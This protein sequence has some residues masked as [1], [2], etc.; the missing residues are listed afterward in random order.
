[1]SELI[2]AIIKT[3]ETTADIFAKALVNINGLSEFEIGEKILAEVAK[4]NE[5]F[6]E[7]WYSP[8]PKGVAVLLDQKL[9]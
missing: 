9:N 8:P 3:R 2:D 6:P 4:H 1:M 5:M 7:G